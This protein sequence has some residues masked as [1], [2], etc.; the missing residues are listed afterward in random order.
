L[1]RRASIAPTALIPILGPRTQ[2]HL[3]EYLR[4]IELRLDD[5][6]YRKLEEAMFGDAAATS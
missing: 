6:H 5:E 1:R 3:E 4:S 2:A